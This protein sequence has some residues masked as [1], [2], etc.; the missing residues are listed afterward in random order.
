M[1]VIAL[2]PSPG[3]SEHVQRIGHAYSLKPD[4]KI[5]AIPAELTLSYSSV[6][7]SEID[8]ERLSLYSWDRFQ[9]NWIRVGGI[10]DP[11]QK[12]VTAVVNYL[13]LFAI[14]QEDPDIYDKPASDDLDI[15]E[16]R[17]SPNTFF[18]PEINRLTIHYDIGYIAQ[19]LV[20]V[21]T[22]IHDIR[23]HV[24]K[25]LLDKSPR[26]PGWNT[27]QWDGTD[28]TGEIVKNGRYF[29]LITAE[30]NGDKVSKVKHLAVFR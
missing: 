10:V 22:K 7:A 26:Y 28:E 12:S 14:M 6:I 24:V 13:T 2:S 8:D 19:Q 16:I 3:T 4:G 18:A 23:G 15:L 1:P 21:T 17:L 9:N 5:F 30:A 27:D 11:Y 25:E 29:L 20:A